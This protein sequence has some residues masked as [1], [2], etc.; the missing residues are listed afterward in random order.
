MFILAN[1]KKLYTALLVDRSLAQLSFERL[2]SAANSDICRHP[3]P[4]ILW[5][6]LGTLIV[7]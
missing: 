6:D 2:R 5:M 1:G 4:N 7:E 3:Q